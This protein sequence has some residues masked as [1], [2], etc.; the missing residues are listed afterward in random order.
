MWLVTASTPCTDD[1]GSFSPSSTFAGI[2]TPTL[3]S[4]ILGESYHFTI[5]VFPGICSVTIYSLF[6]QMFRQFLNGYT[7]LQ[8]MYTT[9]Y[10]CMLLWGLSPPAL[11]VFTVSVALFVYPKR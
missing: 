4:P 11:T 3:G 8:K 5:A 6:V 7:V 9:K 10:G 1:I 2:T